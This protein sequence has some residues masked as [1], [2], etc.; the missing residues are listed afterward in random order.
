[1]ELLLDRA[2]IGKGVV[3][4]EWIRNTIGRMLEGDCTSKFRGSE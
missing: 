3:G 4:I 2:I 1:M